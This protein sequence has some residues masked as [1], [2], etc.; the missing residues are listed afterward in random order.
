MKLRKVLKIQE[1]ILEKQVVQPDRK[2]SQFLSCQILLTVCE[3]HFGDRQERSHSRNPDMIRNMMELSGKIRGIRAFVHGSLDIAVSENQQGRFRIEKNSPAVQIYKRTGIYLAAFV[4]AGIGLFRPGF[5]SPVFAALFLYGKD[6]VFGKGIQDYRKIPDEPAHLVRE[7]LLGS[8]G[9]MRI[10]R[11]EEKQG[12]V[13]RHPHHAVGTVKSFHPVFEQF[14][15]HSG[16]GDIGEIREFR[17]QGPCRNVIVI[18]NDLNQQTHPVFLEEVFHDPDRLKVL[19]LHGN[20]FSD[21]FKMAGKCEEMSAVIGPCQLLFGRRFRIQN[22]ILDRTAGPD[23]GKL[24]VDGGTAGLRFPDHPVHPR[25][26]RPYKA[27]FCIE[28]FFG[29]RGIHRFPERLGFSGIVQNRDSGI[30]FLEFGNL[31]DGKCKIAVKVEIFQRICLLDRLL[32]RHCL[33]ERNH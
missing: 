30:D 20:R 3:K 27:P 21:Q 18:R 25:Q 5:M 8:G 10:F 22:I 6:I 9:G 2:D 26:F 16:R 29:Q 32:F 12:M 31:A 13:M 1:I 7:N 33:L 24:L 15:G 28:R 19:R 4:F 11:I 23:F 17:I 14:P